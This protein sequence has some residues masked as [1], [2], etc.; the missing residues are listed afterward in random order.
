MATAPSPPPQPPTPPK[1][2]GN[3]PRSSRPPLPGYA[4]LP[5]SSSLPVQETSPSP[6]TVHDAEDAALHLIQNGPQ[7]PPS[8][9]QEDGL[10]GAKENNRPVQETDPAPQMT[11]QRGDKAHQT[12]QADE[13]Q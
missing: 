7:S 2:C 9:G 6:M 4:A 10:S 8:E 1:P 5:F 11:E 3:Q 13:D 12:D